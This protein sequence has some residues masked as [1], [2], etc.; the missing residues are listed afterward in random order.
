[1]G[2]KLISNLEA[3]VINA[4]TGKYPSELDDD[5]CRYWLEKAT[6]AI[7]EIREY[8]FIKLHSLV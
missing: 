1:M 6:A 2:D 7:D 4:M 8:L 3:D 5:D